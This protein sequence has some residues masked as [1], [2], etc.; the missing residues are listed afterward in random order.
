MILA[1]RF[2]DRK[3]AETKR[4][5]LKRE[6]KALALEE[7]EEN[8]LTQYDIPASI[9]K[10]EDED[11]TQSNSIMTSLETSQLLP[12]SSSRS[13][14]GGDSDDDDDDFFTQQMGGS[15][16]AARLA[17]ATTLNDSKGKIKTE[18]ED[19]NEIELTSLAPKKPK[20]APKP[21]KTA[22]GG[23]TT[24][25]RAKMPKNS[26]NNP[27]FSAFGVEEENEATNTSIPSQ[28]EFHLHNYRPLPTNSS[29]EECTICGQRMEFETL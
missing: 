15:S 18:T 22:A 3:I 13:R 23:G 19:Q 16:A 7:E 26:R 14:Y 11:V 21:R 2:R 24:R 8:T 29:I 27:I 1:R 5:Q 6:K 4:R 28:V 17:V 12:Q 20:T 10:E 25:P 9:I